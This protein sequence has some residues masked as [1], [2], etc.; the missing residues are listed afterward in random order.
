MSS[1]HITSIELYNELCNVYVRCDPN[2]GMEVLRKLRGASPGVGGAILLSGRINNRNVVI[3]TFPIDCPFK[4]LKGLRKDNHNIRDYG[5]Y[6]PGTGLL[7][8]HLFIL[9]SITQNITTCYNITT[10]EYA[11]D[12]SES[13]CTRQPIP[14]QTSYPITNDPSSLLNSMMTNYNSVNKQGPYDI[15]SRSDSVRFMMVEQC[16]GDIQGLIESGKYTF[17]LLNKM[18]LMVFHTLLI[19]DSTLE[20]Y[21][22]NDLGTRNVLYTTDP[23]GSDQTYWRYHFPSGQSVLSIDISTNTLIPKIWDF[24][25]VRFGTAENYSNF[26]S[27]FDGSTPNL[28]KI[29]EERENDVFIF[30]SDIMNIIRVNGGIVPNFNLENIRAARNNTE[31]VY[32]YLKDNLIADELLSDENHTIVHSF[33]PDLSIFDQLDIDRKVL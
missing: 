6:E 31:A 9:T 24:A 32:S 8:T 4:Y 15:P 10:C 11:Y 30:L 19:F 17:D 14:E 20:G 18:I 3:K 1:Q 16:Q 5:N 23:E 2:L 7:F 29:S 12:V 22:H 25:F 26:Y 33:P 27:Y 21:S 28:T 13:M